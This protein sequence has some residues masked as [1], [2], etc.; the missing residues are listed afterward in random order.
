METIVIA[1]A[2][3]LA[4][5]EVR[6][7]LEKAALPA[8]TRLVSG[9]D[10][11]GSVILTEDAAEPAIMRSLEA[12]QIHGARLVFTAG[13]PEN[14]TRAWAAA[15]GAPSHPIFIDL[16]GALEEQ[17]GARVRAPMVETEGAAAAPVY[18][19]AHSAAIVLALFT[20]RLQEA[21]PVRR[22]VAQ[23]FEPVSERGQGGVDELQQ[24]TVNLLSFQPLTKTLFDAQVSFNMLPQYGA[25]A[26]ASLAAV[27][28]TIERHL[29]SL[30]GPGGGVMPSF[31]VAHA[32]VFHGYTF[33]VW[34]EFENAPEVEHLSERL[35]MPQIEIRNAD[36]EPPSNVGVAGQS[37]ITIGAIAP[38]RNDRRACWFWIAAD[39]LRIA[40]QN[41]VEVAVAVL[42]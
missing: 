2:E 35:A 21:A 19:I 15:Q 4:G 25:E 30:L 20:K 28:N 12:E 29:V 26:R 33:S 39:N 14:A 32:P 38:D 3:S 18:V 9:A 8:N 42:G 13:A 10:E 40:A 37:S 5:R 23:V 7:V 27:E 41:A 22:I 16:T 34:V 31:R 36:E 17:P 6:D 11:P 24:Q 1:G